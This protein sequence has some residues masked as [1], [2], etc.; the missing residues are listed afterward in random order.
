MFTDD[1]SRSVARSTASR[2]MNNHAFGASILSS[3]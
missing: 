3:S 2:A 1:G